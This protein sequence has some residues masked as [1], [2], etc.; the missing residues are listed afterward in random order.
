MIGIV[1][2]IDMILTG[3]LDC[4]ILSWFYTHYKVLSLFTTINALLI[5]NVIT[6]FLERIT[7]QSAFY[8]VTIEL[9]M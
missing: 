8:Y 5:L 9:I 4:M 1:I 2:A 3:V 6:C 7:C